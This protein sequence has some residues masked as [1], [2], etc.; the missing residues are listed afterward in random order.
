MTSDPTI[1][2]N[3]PREGTK[4]RTVYDLTI[5]DG[6][7][8]LGEINRAT[9]QEAWSYKTNTEELARRVGGTAHRDP[10]GGGDNRRF[11]ITIP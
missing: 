6:G 10:P 4:L 7:A 9:D 8:T 1:M 11:W 5:R 2:P 3:L